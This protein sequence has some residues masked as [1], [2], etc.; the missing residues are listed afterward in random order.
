MQKITTA[1]AVGKRILSKMFNTVFQSSSESQNK[2]TAINAI[3]P[4]YSSKEI[5]TLESIQ[6]DH[7]NQV[8]LIYFI[9]EFSLFLDFKMNSIVMPLLRSEGEENAGGGKLSMLL[10]N[11]LVKIDGQV[12]F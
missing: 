8:F 12:I 6:P 9:F 5:G 4:Y 3:F 7:F 2:T 1:A 11:F 10:I